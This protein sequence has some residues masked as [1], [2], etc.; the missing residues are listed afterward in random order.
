[1]TTTLTING[2]RK[3]LDAP[4]IWQALR[5]YLRACLLLG[6]GVAGVAVIVH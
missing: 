3:T 4:D 5:L 1:M 6:V 2:E